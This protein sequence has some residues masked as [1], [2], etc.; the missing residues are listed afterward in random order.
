MFYLHNDWEQCVVHRD[1]KAGNVLLDSGFNVKLGDFGL[2]RLVDHEL[3]PRTTCLAGTLG[4]MAPEYVIS[5]KASS[6]SDVYSFGVVT[7][8][9]VTGRRAT[10]PRND[11][12]GLVE[13]VWDLYRRGEPLLAVDERLQMEFDEQQARCMVM[14]GLWC[15]HPDY[16]LRPSIRQ[17]IQVLNFEAEIPDLPLQMPVPMY[18]VPSALPTESFA[19]PLISNSFSE[20][21]R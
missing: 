1:I 13:W 8:E 7:L 4:Y 16:T 18:Q 10:D 12:M 9:L 17:A 14:V 19:E 6:K 21:G 5:G 15:A 3:D 11:E 2:A 20:A